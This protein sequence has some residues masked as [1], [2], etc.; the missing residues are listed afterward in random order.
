MTVYPIKRPKIEENVLDYDKIK[1]TVLGTG[2]PEIIWNL[3]GTG[4]KTV[5]RIK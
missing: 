2:R 3:P 5:K 1:D 4:K